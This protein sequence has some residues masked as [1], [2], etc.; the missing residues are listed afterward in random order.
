MGTPVKRIEKE[1]VFRNLL[2]KGVSLEVHGNRAQIPCTIKDFDADKI[3]LEGTEADTWKT[4][5]EEDKVNIFFKF[6]DN[7][8]TCQSEVIAVKENLLT[9]QYPEGLYKNLMRKYERIP[10]PEGVEVFFTFKGEKHSLNFPKSEEYSPVTEPELA[11]DFDPSN[12]QDLIRSFKEKAKSLASEIEITMFRSR[13]PETFEEKLIARLGKVLYIPSTSEDFPEQDPFPEGR[14]ITQDGFF[15]Y[16][17]FSPL[18]Q[19]D[20]PEDPVALIASK[21]E[22]NIHAELFCPLLFHQYVVGYIHLVNKGGKKDRIERDALDYVY[23]FS[24]VL[25]YALDL[26]GYFKTEGK[27]PKHFD[28]QIVDMSAS[29]LLFAHNSPELAESLVLYTD[30]ELVIRIGKRKI[31]I[32]GRTM[33]KFKSRDLAYYGIQFLDI[34]PEDFRYLFEFL[35]GRTFSEE[36]E[37]RWEGGALPPSLTMY[38]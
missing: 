18:P 35:Y 12:I 27:E 26:N 9:V 28:A 29:G 14:I 16:K 7:V 19:K 36:D 6:H 10:V 5:S 11:A 32:G 4:F 3:V 13:K 24:K 30:I 15:R 25:I 2:D 20:E 38:D 17:E 8:M 34:K 22:Q 1:F 37:K 33:R 21:K 31:F 23:Q